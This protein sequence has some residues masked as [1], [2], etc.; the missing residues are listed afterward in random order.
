MP[1][2]GE[3]ISATA[4]EGRGQRQSWI[5]AQL[6]LQRIK[7]RVL[8]S[9]TSAANDVEEWAAAAKNAVLCVLHSTARPDPV[10]QALALLHGELRDMHQHLQGPST[11]Q[12]SEENQICHPR[13]FYVSAF[14][15]IMHVAPLSSQVE[16]FGVALAYCYMHESLFGEATAVADALSSMASVQQDRLLTLMACI[17]F[18]QNDIGRAMSVLRGSVPSTPLCAFWLAM[19]WVLSHKRSKTDPSHYQPCTIESADDVWALLQTAI[20]GDVRTIEC[21]ILQAW[22]RT[23]HRTRVQEDITAG[24]CLVKAIC[25][26]FD[27]RGSTNLP[28]F[29]YAMLLGRLGQWA[30][31]Q[32]TLQFCLDAYTNRTTS[33]TACIPIFSAT[34]HVTLPILQ[35]YMARACILSGDLNTAHV[36]LQRLGLA[37]AALD[38]SV[39]PFQTSSLVRDRVFVLLEV[40]AHREAVNVCNAALQRYQGDPALLLYKA[41]ALFCLEQVQECDWTLQQV[42]TVL[43]GVDEPC[44]DLYAQLLNN[45][46]LVLACRGDIADAVQ[47]LH[48]CRH[49]FPSCTHALFNLTVL[50]WRQKKRVAA[51]T[52]WLAGRPTISVPGTLDVEN[53][54]TTHVPAGRRGQLCPQQVAALDRLIETHWADHERM[55]A[56]KQSLQVVEHY[57]SFCETQHGGGEASAAETRP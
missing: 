15:M 46:A 9:P 3:A 11:M 37:T 29:N 28:M 56:I 42:D 32:Q 48:E 51:C 24:D 31:M 40:N 18:Q 54:P 57:R 21:L 34:M 23:H 26:D 16:E 6:A 50:L 36:M 10:I 38:V 39:G 12:T 7:D 20:A 27:H 25:L 43:A 45:Q 35:A 41:D 52:T 8:Q 5:H 44:R 30:D 33:D 53:P 47:K 13:S 2:M 1:E 4:G 17:A 55:H 22:I 14:E 49:K 19:A